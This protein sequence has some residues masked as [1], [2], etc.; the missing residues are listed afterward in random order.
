M[1]N[2]STAFPAA[3]FALIH[4]RKFGVA[5]PLPCPFRL[6]ARGAAGRVL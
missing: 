1:P 2:Q 6:P 4:T 5:R 3:V